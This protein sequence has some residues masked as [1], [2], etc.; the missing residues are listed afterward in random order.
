MSVETDN[1]KS[2]IAMKD[3]T[4]L[5]K[6]GSKFQDLKLILEEK[7]KKIEELKTHLQ[8][9]NVDCQQ[10]INSF[11][12]RLYQNL[13]TIERHVKYI[14]EQLEHVSGDFE[15]LQDQSVEKL[16][17]ESDLKKDEQALN[18]CLQEALDTLEAG[19]MVEKYLPTAEN[20][21]MIEK[22]TEIQKCFCGKKAE[23]P[24]IRT[25]LTDF[26]EYLN[27]KRDKVNKLQ[28]DLTSS[29]SKEVIGK[30]I[31]SNTEKSKVKD[32]GHEF[33]DFLQE[34]RHLFQQ[35]SDTV[36]TLS[37]WLTSNQKCD[38]MNILEVER[39]RSTA[40]EA[41]VNKLKCEM[42]AQKKELTIKNAE[43][44]GM[45]YVYVQYLII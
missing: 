40:L 41:D 16:K 32:A 26:K 6:K 9:S 20:A 29:S 44:E 10:D 34:F 17:S 31:L 3:E 14:R 1:L 18:V 22:L 8:S 15:D 39:E 23:M 4:L 12:Y 42:Y 13:T 2:H 7:C 27:I 45:I 35:L 5:K 43:I 19:I 25:K 21:T 36:N 33:K 11:D 37:S 38:V 30:D 24:E 28:V